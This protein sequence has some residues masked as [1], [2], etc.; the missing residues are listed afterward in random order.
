MT[1]S[2]ADATVYVIDD[3]KS[4]QR[5]LIRLLSSAGISGVAFSSV[6][7]FEASD[8]LTTN[9]CVVADVHMPGISAIDLPGRLEKR[10]LK[11]PVI[12]ITG[13]DSSETRRR[14]QLAGA[15]AYFRKP[16]DDQ[17]LVDTIHWAIDGRRAE[18]E[19]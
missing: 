2:G 12:F 3:E 7:E 1:D 14:A 6:D 4:V 16:V 8:P 15:A 9:A 13:R 18:R 17:A 5:A 11:L 10:G 19:G